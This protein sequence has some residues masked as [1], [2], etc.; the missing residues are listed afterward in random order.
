[1]KNQKNRPCKDRPWIARH[2]V[3]GAK[4]PGFTR[5]IRCPRC[6]RF[7]KVVIQRDDV[8][9]DPSPEPN[10]DLPGVPCYCN[11]CDIAYIVAWM[12]EEAPI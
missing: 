2:L 3:G 5:A 7:D 11:R 8:G 10:K 1:M 12:D 6:D 9:I 4:G